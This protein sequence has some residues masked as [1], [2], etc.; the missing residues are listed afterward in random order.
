MENDILVIGS[1]GCVS[2]IRTSDG[3]ELWRTQLREGLFGGSRGSDVS[4]LIEGDKI[5]AG[6]SGRIY[7][8]RA[9]D[10][11]ILWVNEL[12]GIGFNEVALAR[13]G[14][15]VQFITRVETTTTT[16]GNNNA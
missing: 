7:S 10:G 6:C 9:S 16:T 14:T 1:S 5:F 15:S 13:Q 12:K 3:D 2:A 4:V 11:K 8:L